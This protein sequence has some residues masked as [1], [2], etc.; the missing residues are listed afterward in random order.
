M[1][2]KILILGGTGTVGKLLSTEF[3]NDPSNEVLIPDRSGNAPSSTMPNH[4]IF[5][6]TGDYFEDIKSFISS[7][8]KSPDIIINAIGNSQGSAEQVS[9]DNDQY[10]DAFLDFLRSLDVKRNG[11]KV[12]HLGS[13]AELQNGNKSGYADAKSN[14]RSKLLAS[15]LVQNI[16][17]LP[18]VYGSGINR[19]ADD[20]K[21][22]ADMFSQSHLLQNRVRL[23]L[24][25]GD[26]MSHA[27]HGV[28]QHI[29][30]LGAYEGKDIKIFESTCNLKKFANHVGLPLADT[31]EISEE[32]DKAFLRKKRVE[33][34]SG[35]APDSLK[36]RLLFFI[37]LA[38]TDSQEARDAMNHYTAFC[39][40]A[41]ARQEAN[42]GQKLYEHEGS[43]CITTK[44]NN[45]LVAP[46]ELL[47]GS[48]LS[49]AR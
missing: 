8:G 12:L 44:N 37:D 40:E 1:G 6:A 28:I 2:K 19:I 27:I 26:F 11:I 9:Q 15:G 36:R 46:S 42:T 14:A 16:V 13:V 24:V 38:L 30:K 7:T 17:T 43:T 32:E 21:D 18:I 22:Y 31:E 39:N 4:N 41:S 34:E 5:P 20:L 47:R 10:I 45:F 29:D 25:S 3:A 49:A 23:S 33:I 48:S 35:N